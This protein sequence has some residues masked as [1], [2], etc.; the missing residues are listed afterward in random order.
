MA[1][2]ELLRAKQSNLQEAINSSHTE[3]DSA[4][5]ESLRLQANLNTLLE[6]N[7]G[8]SFQFQAFEQIPKKPDHT[9]TGSTFFAKLKRFLQHHEDTQRQGG[10]IRD[11]VQRFTDSHTHLRDTWNILDTQLH[12]LDDSLR[13]ILHWWFVC[14][15][16]HKDLNNPALH[17][18]RYMHKIQQRQSSDD[19]LR[20]IISQ[21]SQTEFHYT[22]PRVIID[23]VRAYIDG[24]PEHIL[25]HQFLEHLEF[26]APK[27]ANQQTRK[28]SRI[29][30][31]IDTLSIDS[32]QSVNDNF[33]DSITQHQISAQALVW[34]FTN[35]KVDN[36]TDNIKPESQKSRI[37][38]EEH[39]KSNTTSTITYIPNSTVS[40]DYFQI[41]YRGD[42]F[43]VVVADGVSQSAFGG[44]AAQHVA[45]HIH[46]YYQCRG[47]VIEHDH[48]L[49]I[50]KMTKRS[51]QIA[52]QAEMSNRQS[53]HN[54]LD[55]VM[56]YRIQHDGSQTVFGMV[57]RTQQQL[58]CCW[59]GNVR[60]IVDTHN[61]SVLEGFQ[62]N[63]ERFS[64]DT[65][66]FSSHAPSGLIGE[67][68]YQIIDVPTP[69]T[70]HLFSDALE[71]C[72]RKIEEQSL[73]N[74]EINHCA[75]LDDLTL[76]QISIT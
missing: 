75:N 48:I 14:S 71:T 18:Y 53:S 40:E 62:W 30:E 55:S 22:L 66:R 31:L 49:H 38:K 25:H 73:T 52:L 19:E 58:L 74:E 10:E 64:V 1:F 67:L 16:L 3:Y 35:G 24:K 27:Y 21:L 59:A 37:R 9:H 28:V 51:V 57:I 17:I 8:L 69:C 34:P 32:V 13:A 11:I 15:D 12:G 29:L 6:E 7:L 56:N 68:N 61:Q 26:V 5:T 20:A 70:I 76:I 33:N 43:C 36:T 2:F 23:R 47:G 63:D 54:S 44:I 41:Q 45:H 65:S 4:R 39:N 60:I 46:A 42:D 50:L 72:A